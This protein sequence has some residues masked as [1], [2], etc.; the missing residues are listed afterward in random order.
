MRASTWGTGSGQ[1]AE[2][3][4]GARPRRQLWTTGSSMSEGVFRDGVAMQAAGGE[5]DLDSAM[6]LDAGARARRD[7]RSPLQRMLLRELQH[8]FK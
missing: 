6:L 4:D 3:W 5:F 2:R 7:Q 1:P 8:T